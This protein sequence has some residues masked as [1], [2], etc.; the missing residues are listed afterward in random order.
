MAV[1]F[2]FNML[3]SWL[4]WLILGHFSNP[5]KLIL[6]SLAYSLATIYVI[7]CGAF[8][9]ILRTSNV[10]MVFCIMCYWVSSLRCF[11]VKLF[12]NIVHYY[13]A[14]IVAWSFVIFCR[15]TTKPAEVVVCY[16][17]IPYALLILLLQFSFG[18]W[19]L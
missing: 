10:Y 3:L 19:Y 4:D 6:L 7:R 15:P 8:R 5:F 18:H 2:W 13:G 9:Y 11:P 17:A 1:I 16:L 14:L 12:V